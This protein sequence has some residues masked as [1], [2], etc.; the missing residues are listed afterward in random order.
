LYIAFVKKVVWVKGSFGSK[1][2]LKIFTQDLGDGTSDS[3]LT[4][5]VIIITRVLSI[6]ITKISSYS[7]TT[8][9]YTTIVPQ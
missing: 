5:K 7:Y 1:K 3:Y 4:T 2:I 9:K 8:V 6:K